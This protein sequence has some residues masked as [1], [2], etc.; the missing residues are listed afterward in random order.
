MVVWVAPVLGLA[1]IISVASL[2][3]VGLRGHQ[4]NLSQEKQQEVILNSD[5]SETAKQSALGALYGQSGDVIIGVNPTGGA[6]TDQRVQVPGNNNNINAE[7]SAQVSDSSNSG[8]SQYLAGVGT[9]AV[10]A[11]ALGLGLVLVLRGARK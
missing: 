2:I 10:P 11:L 9:M 1:G 6:D 3:G 5:L 8:L 4:E 7:P